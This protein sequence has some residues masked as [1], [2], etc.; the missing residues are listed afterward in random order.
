LQFLKPS[1]SN[2]AYFTALVDSYQKVLRPGEKE[3]ERVLKLSTVG[4]MVECAAMRKEYRREMSIRRAEEEGRDGGEGVAMINWHDFVIVETIEFREEKEVEEEGM[5]MEESDEEEEQVVEEE[6]DIKVVKDYKARVATTGDDKGDGTMVDPITGERVRISEMSEHMRI[7][8]MD[9]KWRE[10]NKRFQSKLGNTNVASGESIV[11]NLKAFSE[12]RKDIFGSSVDREMERRMEEKERGEEAQRILEKYKDKGAK[13]VATVAPPPPQGM[14]A[15]PQG[16]QPQGM[17]QPPPRGMQPPP[18]GIPPA[19]PQQQPGQPRDSGRRGVSN[20]PAWMKNQPGVLPNPT[21]VVASSAGEQIETLKGRASILGGRSREDV[22]VMEGR[23]EKRQKVEETPAMGEG[24]IMGQAPA[25]PPMPAPA[26]E[27]IPDA[28]P[29]A[30]EAFP[31]GIMPP[32]VFVASLESPTISLSV[33]C[34]VDESANGKKW[35]LD[36]KTVTVSLDVNDTVKN[37]KASLSK[38]LGMPQ[39]KMQLKGK[40]GFLKDAHSLAH[41]NLRSGAGITLV[42]KTRG[43]GRK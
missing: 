5:D 29:D 42:A 27:T 39:N 14:A 1:S 8:L 36:G 24:P 10:Q 38:E 9:P 34:P 28:A 26:E 6:G 32:D 17:M 23:D 41:L 22:E 31:G 7:Q 2:F 3:I 11:A 43:G 18:R 21:T 15:Q 25:A 35:G 16:M 12:E 30:A 19:P 37:I 4:G 13:E 20:L 40:D 33:N